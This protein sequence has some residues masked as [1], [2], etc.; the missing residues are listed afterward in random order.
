M[1]QGS[2]VGQYIGPYQL[3]QLIGHGGMGEVWRASATTDQSKVAIKILR[4]DLKN[5]QAACESFRKEAELTQRLR[6]PQSIKVLSYHTTSEDIPY[7]VM[8]YLEGEDLQ[9]KLD[10]EGSLPLADAIIVTIELLKALS[11]LH[12]AGYVHRDIK[13]SNIFVLKP[14]K[15]NETIKIKILDF[16]LAITSHDP[17][18]KGLRGSYLFMAP[19]QIKKQAVTPATDLYGVAAL[20]FT[21]ITGSPPFKPTGADQIFAQLEQDIPLLSRR[22][23][24][25]S[26][27]NALDQL[28]TRCLA[29]EISERPDNSDVVRRALAYILNEIKRPREGLV[30]GLLAAEDDF[31]SMTPMPYRPLSDR[32]QSVRPNYLS[33]RPQTL[34]QNALS[35]PPTPKPNASSRPIAKAWGDVWSLNEFLHERHEQL[36]KV[37]LQSISEYPQYSRIQQHQLRSCLRQHLNVFIQLSTQ[38]SSNIAQQ[39][40]DQIL[41]QT[42][43]RPSAEYAPLLTLSLLSKALEECIPYEWSQDQVNK[44]QHEL[45]R[46][47]YLFRA[48]F[49]ETIATR[50]YHD[51]NHFLY[52]FFLQSS[53]LAM[54][55]TPNGITLN[56]H[57]KLRSTFNERDDDSLTSRHI[58][59]IL[60]GYQ[61]ILPIQKAFESLHQGTFQNYFILE[62][63]HPKGSA[64]KL[65]FSPYLVGRSDKPQ[66]LILINVL[67]E[68]TRKVEIPELHS[69]DSDFASPQ[70]LPWMMTTEVPSLTAE[71]IRSYIHSRSN[72]PAQLNQQAIT[73]QAQVAYKYQAP[74]TASSINPHLQAPI[75]APLEPNHPSRAN[76]HRSIQPHMQRSSKQPYA[77]RAIYHTPSQQPQTS[78]LPSQPPQRSTYNRPSQ[79]PMIASHVYQPHAHISHPQQHVAHDLN[80]HQLAPD[81]LEYSN[82][83]LQE[84]HVFQ[85]NFA[86]RSQEPSPIQETHSKHPKEYQVSQKPLHHTSSSERPLPHRSPA[87]NTQHTSSHQ[88]YP[89][90]ISQ[91]NHSIQTAA[92]HESHHIHPTSS[93]TSQHIPQPSG[94]SH[95]T[96]AALEKPSPVV[97]NTRHSRIHS[98]EQ[99]THTNSSQN[100]LIQIL[101]FVICALLVW[102][103][104]APIKSMIRG[105]QKQSVQKKVYLKVNSKNTRFI[106]LATDEIICQEVDYCEVNPHDEVKVESDGY[107]P[108]YLRPEELQERSDGVWKLVL[109]KRN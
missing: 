41:Q 7:I 44:I 93:H 77:K 11:E 62:N 83:P 65:Q 26:I 17:P 5:S 8:E 57:A 71:N 20:L 103:F 51:A 50:R 102:N 53:E 1:R 38:R 87:T 91:V 73:E 9:K 36:V 61:P 107:Y 37:W 70:A 84:G 49:I 68:Q 3:E 55:C 94:M 22:V 99:N 24:H 92:L 10:R 96:N 23:P 76:T 54:M 67:T 81:A 33:N 79:Q 106:Q 42:Y 14:K 66:V 64:I 104:R 58:F 52:Q 29:K 21:M 72:P 40:I 12:L 108:R 6:S 13:P 80:F 47:L 16:G 63:P 18:E 45:W 27:P 25:L 31:E 86:T 48:K 97:K 75:S 39:L 88:V 100:F 95:T 98:V 34:S 43:T 32:V 74:N 4:E 105:K 85:F 28:V 46:V 19:E 82:P 15:N 69:V 89:S 60:K 78:R 56:T 35:Y 90:N 30:N 101:L 2:Q 109:E 59:D